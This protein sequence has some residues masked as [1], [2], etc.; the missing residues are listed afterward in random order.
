MRSGQNKS[1]IFVCAEGSCGGKFKLGKKFQLCHLDLD[2]RINP[3]D[4]ILQVNEISFANMSYEEVAKIL[5]DVP[6]KAGPIR[7]VVGKNLREHSEYGCHFSRI[8]ISC[9][10]REK[11]RIKK[12]PLC[13][14]GFG[15]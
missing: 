2:G 14:L 11:K 4:K 3:G 9:E 13:S 8:L 7:L 5:K 15:N 12:S 6:Q 10:K 1:W